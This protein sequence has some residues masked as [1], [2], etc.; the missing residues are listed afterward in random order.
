V[1]AP[2]TFKHILV[3]TDFGKSSARA[4]D[5]AVDLATI[6]DAELTLLHVWEFP[7]YAYMDAAAM[8][9]DYAT[10]IA[11]AAEVE[12]TKTLNAIKVRV[13]RA[14]ARLSM[15]VP[16]QGVIAALEELKPDLIVM[17]THG[18][19]GLSHALLGSV[20]EK[21]VRLAPIPVL[22]VPGSAR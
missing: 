21:V 10:P 14:K 15:G 1:A 17:G 19:R 22:T 7:T 5:L 11:Q 4:L 18:R 20:A 12:L 3:P 9:P 6:F 8:T 2:S 13:P 16:W